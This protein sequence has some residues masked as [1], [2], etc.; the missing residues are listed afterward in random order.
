[1]IFICKRDI[2][3]GYNALLFRII[4]TPGAPI[5]LFKG[6]DLIKRQKFIDSVRACYC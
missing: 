1:M 6:R 3:K 4:F 2:L 5:I